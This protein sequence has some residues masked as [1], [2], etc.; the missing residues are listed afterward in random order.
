M[1]TCLPRALLSM[2]MLALPVAAQLEPN[3]EPDALGPLGG[4]AIS[5]VVHPIDTDEMLIIKGSLPAGI[6]RST[7][8]GASFGGAPYGTG[9]SGIPRGLTQDPSDPDTLFV[10]DGN[11]VFKS[12]DFG[13]TWSP[14]S[15]VGLYNDL[16]SLAISATGDDLL[17]LDFFN[18]YHSADGGATWSTVQM[19]PFGGILTDAYYAPGDASVAY[20]TGS[21]DL[22]RSADGGASF[23]GPIPF[24]TIINDIAIS[25]SDPD[26]LFLCTGFAGLFHSTDGGTTFSSIGNAEINDLHG[27]WFAW[28]PD[29]G[30]WFAGLTSTFYSADSGSSWLEI[31]EGWPALKPIMSTL[32]V[33]TQGVRYLGT[34]SNS[35]FG[36]QSGGGL[37][38]MPAGVPAAWEHIAFLASPIHA[39]AVASPGGRRVIGLGNG[40]YSGALG[41]P[42]A[43]TSLFL[44]DTHALAV[45][46]DDSTRWVAGGLINLGSTARVHVLSGDGDSTVMTY[47]RPGAGAVQDIEFDPF[48]SNRLMAGIFPA[49]SGNQALIRSS[50]RGNSWVDVAGTAGWATRAVAYDPHTPGR[51]LQLSYNNQWS[52]SLDGGSTWLPLQFAWAGTGPAMLLVFDPFVPDRIYRGETGSGLWRSDDGGDNWL[53]MGVGLSST[54]DLL[55]HPEL[56]GMLWV[57]DDSGQI[58]VS[59]DYAS[60]FEVALDVPQGANGSALALDVSNGSLLLGTDGASAWELSGAS[61]VVVLGGGTQGSGGLK[62]IFSTSGGLPQL[63][64][65]LFALTGEDLVGGATVFVVLG[66]AEINAPVFGG[67]FHVGGIV[68]PIIAFS[69]GGA[70]GVPGAGAF[71]M[72]APIPSDPILAGFSVIAQLG[73]ADAGASHPTGRVLSNGLRITMIN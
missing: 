70:P 14:L 43:P 57:S 3:S 53:A 4:A 50:N 48:D 64:S 34:E 45:D 46:P 71:S 56:P 60:S 24:T 62:P 5:V 26:E 7:D 20:M 59:V 65:A 44:F 63:G 47:D 10:R 19:V 67:V 32:V 41:E 15:L 72:S 69:V 68:E 22:Y 23:S 73:V 30:L 9:L 40:V 16:K 55:C 1:T 54:S 51:V 35:M 49:S 2:L 6:F 31:T 17:A 8:A 38:R 28:D 29:G 36:D 33:D 12:T 21:S 18:A 11:K 37:Y 66:V 25:P 27:R 52:Q 61:P 13:A 39:V 42:V 58:L